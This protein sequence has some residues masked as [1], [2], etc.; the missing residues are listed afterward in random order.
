MC[1]DLSIIDNCSRIYLDLCLRIG[2]DLLICDVGFALFGSKIA[3]L[4]YL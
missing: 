4:S 3:L 1:L 2:S